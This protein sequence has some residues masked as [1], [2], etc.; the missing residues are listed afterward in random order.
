MQR[1]NGAMTVQRSNGCSAL[2]RTRKAFSGGVFTAESPSHAR[3]DR[4]RRILVGAYSQFSILILRAGLPAREALSRE[5]S[6]LR[7]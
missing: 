1:Y 4:L 6:A 2:T 3:Q 5:I 7:G